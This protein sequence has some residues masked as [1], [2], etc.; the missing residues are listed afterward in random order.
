MTEADE[1]AAVLHTANPPPH[2]RSFDE[3]SAWVRARMMPDESMQVIDNIAWSLW[4][5]QP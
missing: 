4:S 5:A 1:I 2:F 3:A